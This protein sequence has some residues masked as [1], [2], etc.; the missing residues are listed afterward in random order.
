[1]ID[2][3]VNIAFSTDRNYIEHTI[4]AIMSIIFNTNAKLNFYI[5]SSDFSESDRDRFWNIK[6]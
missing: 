4:V 5:L 3:T 1:M 2:K 6:K